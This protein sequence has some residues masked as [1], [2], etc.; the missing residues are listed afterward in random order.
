MRS[1]RRTAISAYTFC[2][3]T[4]VVYIFIGERVVLHH[5]TLSPL[6]MSRS[7]RSGEGG[8]YLTAVI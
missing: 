5:T 7:Y 2:M 8:C 6:S 3:Q 4:D 1:G